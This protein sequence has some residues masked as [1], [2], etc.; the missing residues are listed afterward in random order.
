MKKKKQKALQPTDAE[1]LAF[2]CNAHVFVQGYQSML[3]KSE[4]LL[5]DA[6]FGNNRYARRINSGV[7]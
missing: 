7:E 2:A 1:A 6:L 3:K 5:A 4:E